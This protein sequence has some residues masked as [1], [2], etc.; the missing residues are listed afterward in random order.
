MSGQPRPSLGGLLELLFRR[1]LIV[2]AAKARL[3]VE[4]LTPRASYDRGEPG[5]QPVSKPL[6]FF[7]GENPSGS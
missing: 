7:V 2:H 4:P 3:F 1:R 6:P 5:G